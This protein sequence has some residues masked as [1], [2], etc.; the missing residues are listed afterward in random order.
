MRLAVLVGSFPELSERF[1]VNQLT[2][3]IDAGLA[4]QIYA[5]M[6]TRAAADH[7]LTSRYGLRE[8]TIYAKIPRSIRQRAL[9]APRVLGSCLLSDP[10]VALKA[11]D[12]GAYT[13]AAKNLKTLYFLRAFGNRRYDLLHC[14]FGPYGLVGAFL[15]DS[16]RADRLVVTF[17]GSDINGYPRRYGEGVY[18]HLY[19]AADAVTCG[20]RFIRDKLVA[21]GCPADKVHILPV[22]LRLEDYPE[23]GSR[24]ERGLILSVGRLV[25]V[26]GFRYAIEAFA[27]LKSRFPEARYIIA[28]DGPDRVY[29]A[30]LARE[31]GVSES[32]S[33]VGAQN[34]V[35]IASLYRRASVLVLPSVRASNG[36]EE[37]QG[38]V[39]Q[40]AQ[41]SGLPVVSTLVG[42]IPEGMI[43]GETGYLVPEKDPGALA[44]RIGALL[45]DTALREKMGKAGRAFVSGTYDIPILTSRLIA[46]YD[47]V[48]G[49]KEEGLP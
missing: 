1:I 26:K 21:N 36:A 34:D 7:E 33:F 24:R 18:R 40:E 17:H 5:A 15:K 6:A 16:G 28:G 29:L 46:I 44:E 11:F 47:E 41:V 43:E 3:L 49:R 38:L 42:G 39:L 25:E 14:H 22:G 8:K 35:E 9:S 37:G 23:S 45:S 32:V 31:L 19:E 2:G 20:S 10:A 12:T 13:T 4:P 27:A 30:D 48:L